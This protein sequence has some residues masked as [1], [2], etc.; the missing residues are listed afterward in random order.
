MN[1]APTVCDVACEFHVW[2]RG[3]GVSSTFLAYYLQLARAGGSDDGWNERTKSIVAT[4]LA[5]VKCGM[6][7]FGVGTYLVE[8]SDF[9]E[10]GEVLD[11]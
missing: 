2:T 3:A 10:E 1:S 8:R 6:P 7:A 11:A 5:V 9:D 4:S